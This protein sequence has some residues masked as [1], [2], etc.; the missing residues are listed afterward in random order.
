MH[1][2]IAKTFNA[3]M[4]GM[5]ERERGERERKTKAVCR[6]PEAGSEDTA[7]PE[8]VW[9]SEPMTVAAAPDP[10]DPDGP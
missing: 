1:S 8:T 9:D 3:S 5:K 7:D 6:L 10:E 4:L 2:I